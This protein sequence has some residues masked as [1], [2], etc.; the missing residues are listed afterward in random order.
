VQADVR[1]RAISAAA[2]ESVYGCVLD[3][4]GKVDVAATQRRREELLAQRRS[5][6]ANTTLTSGP[7]GAL[8]R[9]CPLGDQMEIVSD[10]MGVRWTR[11]RC[12]AVLAR[13]DEGWRNYAGK[14][15]GDPQAPGIGLKLHEKLELREYACRSCG[16]LHA[17]DV[18]RK[19]SPEPDD[20][21]FVF[22]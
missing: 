16:R 10:G 7:A 1:A 5:W 2:A 12:T 3:A 6:P 13:A 11:C 22:G 19:G 9:V 4:A 17:V 15:V 20:I 21:R 14:H 18:C 8:T